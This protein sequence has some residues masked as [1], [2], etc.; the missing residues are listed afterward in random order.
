[1]LDPTP[2]FSRIH[3]NDAMGPVALLTQRI[4]RNLD[5][6][7]SARFSIPIRFSKTIQ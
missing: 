2:K 3:Y 5:K 6:L 1:M 4:S 7:S